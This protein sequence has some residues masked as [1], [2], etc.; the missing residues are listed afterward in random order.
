MDDEKLEALVNMSDWPWGSEGHTES[1]RNAMIE[2]YRL[3]YE[4][5]RDDAAIVCTIKSTFW[6]EQTPNV[7]S[8]VACAAADCADAI[9][10]L[11]P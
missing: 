1:V 4:R 8:P 5:A 9:R 2:A 11:K 7:I 6:Q 3:G 10:S